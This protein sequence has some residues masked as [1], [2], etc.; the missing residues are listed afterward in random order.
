LHRRDATGKE[1]QDT[2]RANTG[3]KDRQA[4]DRKD[5]SKADKGSKSQTAASSD[6]D[7]ASK[8]SPVGPGEKKDGPKGPVYKTPQECFDAYAAADENFDFKKYIACLA[9][10]A[11]QKMAAEFALGM[12]NRPE[13]RDEASRKHAEM[14][15]PVVDALH[16][17]G[18]TEKATQGIKDSKDPTERQKAEKAV[19]A[20]IK[21]PEAFLVDIQAA[22]DRALGGNSGKKAYKQKLTDLKIEGD[23]ASGIIVMTTKFSQE[24]QSVTFVKSYHGW[25]ILDQQRLK[26]PEKEDKAPKTIAFRTTAVALVKKYLADAAA[27][28]KKYRNKLVEVEGVVYHANKYLSTSGIQLAGVKKKPDDFGQTV[29]ICDVDPKDGP[30]WLLG[31]GQKVKVVGHFVGGTDFLDGVVLKDC[32]ITPLE[33]SPTRQVTAVQLTADFAKGEDAARKKY[34]GKGREVELIVGGNIAGLRK[35]DFG[36]L[37][38][39]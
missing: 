23:R 30:W 16:R 33:P 2:A 12:L 39:Q 26:N 13:P 27:L 4:A 8:T 14:F 10:Q 24:K 35:G 18:L 19:L 28:N 9:L 34:F 37:P 1:G 7:R 3:R 32:R 21:D 11:Q 22:M 6:K 17:H 15:K 20:L 38:G 25:R 5:Q 29:V 31:R 36:G